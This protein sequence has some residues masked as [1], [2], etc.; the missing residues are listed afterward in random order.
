MPCFWAKMATMPRKSS[1]A[2]PALSN[3]SNQ[4]SQFLPVRRATA[5]VL[6][7]SISLM[8]LRAGLLGAGGS[9]TMGVTREALA[10]LDF[11]ALTGTAGSAAG[12]VG[13][14]GLASVAALLGA[15]A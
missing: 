15:T 5:S 6:T 7:S 2:A 4:A 13:A 1:V 11:G 8:L 3:T 10:L 9:S 12:L 14:A